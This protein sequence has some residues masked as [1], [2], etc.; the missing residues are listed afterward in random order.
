MYVGVVGFSSLRVKP[1]TVS[2]A[3]PPPGNSLRTV[4][5]AWPWVTFFPALR[6]RLRGA[7]ASGLLA[8]SAAVRP[9][10]LSARGSQP[11]SAVAASD[12]PSAS[13]KGQR[14]LGLRKAAA[15]GCRSPV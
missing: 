8:I 3:S 6:P 11:K 1:K 13:G 15:E 14:V 10:G 4:T 5:P 7:A 9:P 2:D 12:Q